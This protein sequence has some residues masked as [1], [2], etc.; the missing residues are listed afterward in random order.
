MINV[1]STNPY[2][3]QVPIQPMPLV[4][5]QYIPQVGLDLNI[6]AKPMQEVLD[7]EDY[8]NELK[9]SNPILID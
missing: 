1:G 2:Q 8:L 6:G 3:I 5:Y 9:K 7:N 4:I